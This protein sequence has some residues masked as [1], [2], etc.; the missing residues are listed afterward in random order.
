MSTSLSVMVVDDEMEL[1]ELFSRFLKLSGFDCD[2]FTDPQL[3]LENFKENFNR[4]CLVI[5]DLKMPKLDGIKLTKRLRKYNKT[6]KI[7]LVTGFL[8]EEDIDYE[9]AKREGID[10]VLEKP[11]HIK[12]LIPTIKEILAE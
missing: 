10:M 3:A 2:Y 7:L 6:V 4:Y 5:V 9:Q 8:A 1:A 11:F 12:E